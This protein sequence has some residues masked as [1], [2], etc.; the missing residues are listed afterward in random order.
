MGLSM[1]ANV[2]PSLAALQQR[3]ELSEAEPKKFVFILFIAKFSS[4][5]AAGPIVVG[6]SAGGVAA[7]PE[8][9]NVYSC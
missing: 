9:E 7:S 1:Q 6:K 4:R 2:L 5:P 8:S 3:L